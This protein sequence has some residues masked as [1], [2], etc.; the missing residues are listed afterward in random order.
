M[1]SASVAFAVSMMI[2][3]GAVLRSARSARQ[4]VRPST[5]GNIRSSTTRSGGVSRT[6]VTTSRPDSSTST[7]KPS[8][9]R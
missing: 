2:G 4:I 8:F 7:V 6:R 1:R 5:A 3:T 9:S